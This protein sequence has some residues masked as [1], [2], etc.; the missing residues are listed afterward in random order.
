MALG[1][2]EELNLVRWRL[3]EPFDPLNP[4][5]TL[6]VPPE[7]RFDLLSRGQDRALAKTADKTAEQIEQDIAALERYRRLKQARIDWAKTHW[8]RVRAWG[9]R[10]PP[11]GEWTYGERRCRSWHAATTGGDDQAAA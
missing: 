9:A 3:E 2:P 8:M 10:K 7:H 1:Y 6:E 5:A 11:Y 4:T